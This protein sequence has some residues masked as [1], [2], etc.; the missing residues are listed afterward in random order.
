MVGR[1]PPGNETPD[2]RRPESSFDFFLHPSVAWKKSQRKVWLITADSSVEVDVSRP[3]RR[4]SETYGEQ[5][6]RGRF[7]RF[8]LFCVRIW[9]T[10]E[11]ESA[12]GV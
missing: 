9:E 1:W 10:T 4:F 2:L 6:S 12:V 7:V 5:V 11:G 3:R 8:K